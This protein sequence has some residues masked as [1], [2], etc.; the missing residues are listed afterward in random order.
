MTKALSLRALLILVALPASLSCGE[1]FD[2][3]SFV[4]NLRVVAAGVEVEG[5]PG[6]ANPDP[7]DTVTVTNLVIDR[8]YPLIE[9]G[10][11][12]LSPPPLQWSLIACVPEP[13]V[14]SVDLCRIV[15]P[16]EGCIAT[17]PSDPLDLPIVTFTIPSA[18]EL[19]AANASNV[20]LQ[21]AICANGPPAG[22]D[23]IIRFFTGETDD[24]DP[25]EDPNNEGRFISAQVLIEQDPDDPNLNPEIADVTLDGEPW[26]PPFDQ[27][28]PRDFPETGCAAVVDGSADL[29]RGGDSASLIR[30]TA[31]DE[32]FQE[33]MIDD[34][35]VTEEMQVSWLGTAGAFEFSFSFITDPLRTATIQWVPPAF[36]SPSGT[37]VRFTFPMRDRASPASSAGSNRG[38]VVWVERGL[39]ILPGDGS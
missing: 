28:V 27:G 10:P 22:P 4:D 14:L 21:G 2:P 31:T 36:P 30:L 24:L 23:A 32:S 19:E 16:C 15:L 39:C 29:P 5:K 25:C 33:I 11:P 7:G 20:V 6:R 3:A 9:G 34:E 35:V 38:G 17:P 37:L 1:S 13:S 8:G 12:P 26:P 18:E